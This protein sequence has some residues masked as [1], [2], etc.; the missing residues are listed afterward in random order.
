MKRTLVFAGVVTLFLTS[1]MSDGKRSATSLH[2]S[3]R[4]PFLHVEG[5]EKIVAAFDKDPDATQPWASRN[6]IAPLSLDDLG[7]TGKIRLASSEGLYLDGGS[8]AYLI[9]DEKD[10]LFAFCT[11]NPNSSA[12]PT[13]LLGRLHFTKTGSLRV[14]AGSPSY[15]FLHRLVW[16][17]SRDPRYQLDPEVLRR[18]LKDHKISE[19]EFEEMAKE[20]N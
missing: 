10:R 1:C 18:V 13:F 14:S 5:E 15:E 3:P 11:S 17:F 7:L 2:S 9:A 19:K 6:Q 20:P 4:L 8:H 16:S 12:P